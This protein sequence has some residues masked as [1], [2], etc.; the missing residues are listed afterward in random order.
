[1]LVAQALDEGLVLA[2]RDPSIRQYAASTMPA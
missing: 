1:M 2:T